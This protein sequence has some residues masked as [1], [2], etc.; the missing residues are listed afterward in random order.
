MRR[1]VMGQ[2]ARRI[3]TLRRNLR[4]RM[5]QRAKVDKVAVLVGRGLAPTE[6]TPLQALLEPHPR[7]AS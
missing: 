4:G 7:L 6:L 2:V 3:Q 1:A 5:V